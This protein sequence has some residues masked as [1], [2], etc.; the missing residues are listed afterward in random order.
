VGGSSVKPSGS[1]ANKAIVAPSN[2]KCNSSNLAAKASAIKIS[3][4][5]FSY[6]GPAYVDKFRAKAKIGHLAWSGTF[7]AP[8]RVKGKVRFASS[9]TPKPGGARITFQ[10]KKCDSG[11]QSWTGQ[12]LGA[13][14]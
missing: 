10:N 6:D 11:T 3:A 4:G 13:T 8:N 7:T 14:R 1:G 9:V 5:R 12:P 2:F